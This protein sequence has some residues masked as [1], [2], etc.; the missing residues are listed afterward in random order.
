MGSIGSW[1]SLSS[2]LAWSTK[3]VP[4]Q[5]VHSVKPGAEPAPRYLNT[6]IRGRDVVFGLLDTEL[7]SLTKSWLLHS[8]NICLPLPSQ[9]LQSQAASSGRLLL[10][11]TA[12]SF[13][14]SSNAITDPGTTPT[15]ARLPGYPGRK[16]FD[17]SL[18]HAKQGGSFLLQPVPGCSFCWVPPPSPAPPTPRL[19]WNSLCRP[20]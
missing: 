16:V 9:T 4:G 2:S 13:Q 12:A 7:Q 5:S 6:G 17:S 11:P 19:T 14:K 15:P 20:G 18:A 8:S 3:Q 1:V 10:D